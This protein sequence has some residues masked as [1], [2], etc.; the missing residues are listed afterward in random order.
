[1]RDI[2]KVRRRGQGKQRDD[3]LGGNV[4]EIQLAVSSA[5]RSGGTY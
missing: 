5:I 4:A 3:D 2:A 1:M